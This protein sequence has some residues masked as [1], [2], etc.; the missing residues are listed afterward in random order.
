MQTA[1]PS[2]GQVTG[3]QHSSIVHSSRAHFMSS[4]D[5]GFCFGGIYI[6]IYIIEIYSNI[7]LFLLV[8]LLV[9]DFLLKRVWF[10]IKPYVDIYIYIYIY[11]CIC[12]EINSNINF[13]MYVCMFVCLFVC[14]YVCMFVCLYVC[15]F[16]CLLKKRVME[17]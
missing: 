6:Y 17:K 9:F 15:M 13:C 3:S 1:V 11:I 5:F 2:A 7:I 4:S 16:V 12:I 10:S 14:L 8:C